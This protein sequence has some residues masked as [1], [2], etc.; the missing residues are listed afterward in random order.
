MRENHSSSPTRRIAGAALLAAGLLLA[1]HGTAEAGK[2]DLK[3]AAANTAGSDRLKIEDWGTCPGAVRL[4]VAFAGKGRKFAARDQDGTVYQGR[5]DQ[6]GKNGRKLDFELNAK[7]R[8]RLRKAMEDRVRRCTGARSVKSE[9]D[10]LL[11]TGKINRTLDA[12]K[13]K[14]RLEGHG[15]TDLGDGDALYTFKSQGSLTRVAP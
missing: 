1:T 5:Y 4:V 7:S 9:I 6:R 2:V 8:K 12:I 14:C 10:R 11:L 13:L 15:D 3:N